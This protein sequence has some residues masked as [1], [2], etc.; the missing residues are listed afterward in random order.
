MNEDNGPDRR[1]LAIGYVPGVQPDKWLTRWRE[2]NPDVPISARRSGDPRSALARV[3]G[4]EG[5]DVIFLREPDAAPR[6]SPPGLLRVP[7]YTETMAVLA[8][9]DHELAAFDTVAV[10]DLEGERW[11]DPVDA[12]AATPA[13]VSAAVDLVAAG[14]GLLVLPLP[15]ARSLSRR[16]VVVRP[17]DGVPATRMGVAWSTRREGDELIDE[18][19]GIVRGRTAATTRGGG[20][21]PRQKLNAKQKTAAKAARARAGQSRGEQPRGRQHAPRGKGRSPRGR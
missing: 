2:R 3:A 18:F 10:A 12:I 8:E 19:V 5:F 6:S 16:D 20:E 1:S 9:K 14:V 11:L 13:E 17:I 4:D 21:P 15:Y 7:L